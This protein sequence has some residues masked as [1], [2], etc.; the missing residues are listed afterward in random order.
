MG[1]EC[2]LLSLPLP[3]CLPQV[4]S[5]KGISLRF[6]R[7]IRVREDKKPEQATTSA[8]VRPMVERWVV[9]PGV[10]SPCQASLLES[11]GSGPIWLGRR[12]GCPGLLTRPPPTLSPQVAGLYKKQSQIQNQQGAE[13]DSEQEEFY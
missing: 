1:G 5:E 8:Q 7:F 9:G 12:W 2:C 6:P 13:P 11:V 3:L 4:D 10:G